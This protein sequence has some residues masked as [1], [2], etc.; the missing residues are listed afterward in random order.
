MLTLT[1]W[2]WSDVINLSPGL[3]WLMSCKEWCCTRNSVL[4]SAIG[5]LDTQQP[6]ALVRSAVVSGSPWRTCIPAPIA[7]WVTEVAI[8]RGWLTSTEGAVTVPY[9]EGQDCDIIWL[10]H[11]EETSRC[12]ASKPV[13]VNMGRIKYKFSLSRNIHSYIFQRKKEKRHITR[14]WITLQVFHVWKTHKNSLSQLNIY[15]GEDAQ[16]VKECRL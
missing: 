11:T 5:K 3:S 14:K 1:Q 7:T 10:L 15:F 13:M 6:V 12:R 16:R 9:L 2:K 4:I 8:E